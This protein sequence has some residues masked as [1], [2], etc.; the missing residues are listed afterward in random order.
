M[1]SIHDA[2]KIRPSIIDANAVV[3]ATSGEPALGFGDRALYSF[4]RGDK[5]KRTLLSKLAPGGTVVNLGDGNLGVRDSTGTIRPVDPSTVEWADL[6]D[7]VGDI[8]TI[9]G[10]TIGG[11]MG[12][13]AGAASGP[14]AI[15][16]GAVGAASGSAIGEVVRQAASNALGS[17]EG[18]DEGTRSRIFEPF[19]TTKGLGKGTG[20]GLAVVYGVANSHHGFAE[21]ETEP[22]YQRKP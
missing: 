22:G 3:E 14:G 20:L 6:A 4:A 9:A 21:V 5:A 17:G 2:N 7:I 19:Y 12:V 18:M 15:A 11:I 10:G 1:P 13:G 16:T 8:P